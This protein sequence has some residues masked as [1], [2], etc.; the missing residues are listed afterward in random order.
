M[1]LII[2]LA[3]AFGRLKDAKTKRWIVPLLDLQM[4]LLNRVTQT[5]DRLVLHFSFR[6]FPNGA[7]IGAESIIKRAMTILTAVNGVSQVS[8][9]F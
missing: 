9:A 1:H 8:D 5:G 6:L 3:E 2:S 4:T 7:R